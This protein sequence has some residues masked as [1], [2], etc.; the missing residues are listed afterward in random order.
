MAFDVARTRGL[1]PSLGDGWI[2]LDPQVSAQVP[3]SVSTTVSTAF[4]AAL[5]AQTIGRHQPRRPSAH[6]SDSIL[7][8]ARHAI[9]DLVGADPAGVV[10]GPNRA[11]LLSHLATAMTWRIGLGADIVLSRLDDEENIVPWLRTA[12]R[13]GAR[14]RWAEVDI[15]SAALPPWQF[16]EIIGESTRL[17][18]VTAA[19][20]LVGTVTEVTAVTAAA[21]R[22]GALSVIDVASLVPY[23]LVDIA[24]LGADILVMDANLWGGPPIGA[25]VFADPTLPD[26]LGSVS[27][28]PAA[29]GAAR[30]EVGGH[31]FGMLGGLIAS[32]EHL[33]SLDES[34][35][36]TRRQRLRQSMGALSYQHAHLLDHLVHSLNGLSTVTVVGTPPV[37]VPRVSFLVNGV[38]ADVVAARLFGNGIVAS[39]P[40]PGTSRL[41]DAIGVHDVGGVVT[42]GLAPYTTSHDIDHLVRVIASLA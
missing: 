16:A 27:L 38:R 32:V 29:R 10:L 15:E 26:R 39:V 23:E 21:R 40:A 17:V 4:R 20:S 30:L 33:A 36:G 37:R 19:N 35:A 2:H 3:E 12:D 41:L 34:A 14:V 5:S 9:A 42:V 13:F 31:Q 1:F 18:A 25:L 28:D 7:D 6:R 8:A 24:E 11:V 22:T